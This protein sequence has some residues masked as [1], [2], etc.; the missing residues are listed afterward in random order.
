MPHFPG[1]L[2][3]SFFV[4]LICNRESPAQQFPKDV[5]PQNAGPNA[6]WKVDG[7]APAQWS[8]IH[9]RNLLW[10]TTLPEGGQSSLTVWKD[11]VFL[12]CHLPLESSGEVATSKDIEGYCLNAGSGEILWKVTIP[13]T[14]PVGT[15]G[16]FSDATVFAPVTDGKYVW[17]F[18]RSGGLG[19]FDMEGHELWTRSYVPRN[20]HTNR[21]A[22]PILF[23][24]Q[25]I[26]VEVLDKEAGALLR[27]HGKIPEGVNPR[28]VWTY[29][30]GIDKR[31]GEVLWTEPAGTVIHNTPMMG[32]LRDG[33]PGI[34]HARGGGHGPL[35]VPFGISLTSLAPKREGRQIWSIEVPR[36]DPSFNSHWDTENVYAFLGQDHVI[37]SSSN[38][39]EQARQNL[40]NGVTIYRHI[41]GTQRWEKEVD[42]SVKP[43][44]RHA[45][46][47]QSNIV[48]GDWHY[49]LAHDIRAIGRVNISN[50]AVE[51]L[52]V[53]A[54]LIS[55]P[56][57]PDQFAWSDTEAVSI[58]A[59]NSRGIDLAGDKRATRTGWGHVSAASPI[60][61]G[62][63]LYFPVMTG[64]VYV[65]DAFAAHLDGTALLAVCDLGETG[66]T[67]TLSSL[68]YAD[69]VLFTRT[70]KEAI[71]IRQQ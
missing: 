58:V 68:S 6:N 25:L 42:A 30:H 18:N 50:G 13:G 62:R 19:C 12:T 8:V 26:T 1:H 49:F 5:W 15:A 57:R 20:R 16:I 17:F 28:S 55:H 66:K 63:H 34:I 53:P 51:Y 10:K 32:Y 24:N 9:H 64:T 56:G 37:Y 47:N 43:G 52:E 23:G 11:R 54:Q 41:P 48:V 38:G 14:V 3:F 4:F 7:T 35:E 29:L 45:N 70:M 65:V 21:Q 44:R 59:R 22:E 33:S 61:V 60:L 31:T 27:R 69:G 46:T 40:H 67:W 71:A 39:Q 36:L 2:L